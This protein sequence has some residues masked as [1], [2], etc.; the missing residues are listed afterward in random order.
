MGKPGRIFFLACFVVAGIMTGMVQAQTN[1]CNPYTAGN[2][3]GYPDLCIFADKTTLGAGQK[4]T[5]T[6]ESSNNLVFGST[7]ENYPVLVIPYSSIC[8]AT[9]VSG[10]CLDTAIQLGVI[11][12]TTQDNV[13]G[14][15]ISSKAFSLPSSLKPGNYLLLVMYRELSAYYPSVPLI[16]TVTNQTPVSEIPSTLF[17]LLPVFLAVIFALGRRENCT[18]HQIRNGPISRREC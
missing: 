6:L 18:D 9:Y 7:S 10:D 14:T 13:G 2:S 12:L 15:L 8:S 4:F 16:I 17:L 3:S 1:G 5:L 11:T